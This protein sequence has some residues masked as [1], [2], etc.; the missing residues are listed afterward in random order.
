VEPHVQATIAIGSTT[1]TVSRFAMTS[2]T[3]DL[4]DVLC[5][6]RMQAES[7]Q[8]I[9]NIIARK[10][11]ERRAGD[12]VFFWGVGNA[13]SRSIRSLAARGDDIDVVFSLMKSRPKLCDVSPAG[14]VVWRT[15]FDYDDVERLLPPHVIVTSRMEVGSG[16]KKVHYALMCRSDQELQLDDQGPFDPSAYRNVGDTGGAIGSSQVTALVVRTNSASQVSDYRINLRAR[17]TGSY[18]VKLAQPRALEEPARAALVIASTH[19]A[20]M[21]SNDWIGM[22][23]QIRCTFPSP[24]RVRSYLF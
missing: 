6:T 14:V 8:E 22:A 13:P 3:Q 17:L 16:L 23:S 5:W 10:E 2:F 12:G 21:D 9:Q 7:G 4:T 11:L 20:E 1:N 18:W 24:A 15:Y 19:T